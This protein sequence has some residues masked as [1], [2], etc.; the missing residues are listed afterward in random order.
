M[1]PWDE[2]LILLIVPQRH[3]NES[4]KGG[5][6]GKGDDEDDYF[7]GNDEKGGHF[8]RSKCERRG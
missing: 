6:F 3:F 1:G 4:E 5:H 8:A 2:W 7:G